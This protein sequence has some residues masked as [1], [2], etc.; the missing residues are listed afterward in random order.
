M[1]NYRIVLIECKSLKLLKELPPLQM[2][3]IEHAKAF[4][5]R[6]FSPLRNRFVGV[7]AMPEK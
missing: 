1:K 3:S 6:H 4:G 2:E 5:E 7:E